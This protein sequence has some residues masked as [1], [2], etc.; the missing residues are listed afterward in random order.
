[1]SGPASQTAVA[2]SGALHRRAAALG[3]ALGALIGWRRYLLSLIL[4][5]FAAGA[6]PPLYLLPLL[7]PAFT[8]LLWLLDGAA[9]RREAFFIGWA[10]GTGHFVAGLYWVRIAFFVDADRFGVFAPAAVLGL[11]AGLALFPAAAVLLLQ[12]SGWR[13]AARLF[14]LAGLWLLAEWLRGWLLTGFPWNLM[15]TVWVFSDSA[16]QLASVAGVWGLS[17]LTVLFAAAP[18]LLGEPGEQTSGGTRRRL[19]LTLALAVIGPA[20]LWAGGAL[21]LAAAPDAGSDRVPGVTLRLV[22]PSIEQALKWH[23]ELRQKHVADQMTMTVEPG[24]EKITHVIWA[25]T[26]VPFFLANED[27]LRRAIAPI[28]PPDGYLVTGAPRS[29]EERRERRLWNALHAMDREGAVVATYDKVKLVPFG[30]FVP[31]RSWLGFAK[32][33]TGGSDFTAGPGRVTID[34]PGLPPFSP[35]ICYEVIF[36]GGVTA[37]DERPQWLLSV[38]ND[39]WFGTSS[40]PYQH[41][42]NARL[43][44]VEEGLPMVRVANNGITAVV[45]GYGR[46]LSRLGQNHRG[47]IDTHLPQAIESA[48]IFATTSNYMVIVILFVTAILCFLTCRNA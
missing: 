3:A 13:G 37:P 12:M 18:A 47:L 19:L 1:L 34:L 7:W 48:T 45:D 15:G 39:A 35:L 6:L 8:G 30:E 11:S 29:E 27:A 25:E 14:L 38:T 33:T 28:V 40:G 43:R 16:I 41:F 32:L 23:P 31:L 24:F 5:G 9:R 46:V 36:P 20:L 42:A 17:W 2:P 21:R 22:Q 4:G 44:A 26:A 10:F